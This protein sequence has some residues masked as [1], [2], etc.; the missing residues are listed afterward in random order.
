[1]ARDSK[2]SDRCST[3][4]QQAAGS[5]D[6]RE[7]SLENPASSLSYFQPSLLV[8]ESSRVRPLPCLILD[9]AGVSRGGMGEDR[10]GQRQRAEKRKRESAEGRGEWNHPRDQYGNDAPAAAMLLC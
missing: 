3:H 5:F 6:P 10:D 9:N 7:N 8:C 1:M 2:L 4:V